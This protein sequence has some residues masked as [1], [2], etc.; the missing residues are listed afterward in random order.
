MT[1]PDLSRRSAVLASLASTLLAACG[2]GGG[3]S[4]TSTVRAINLTSDLA[5]LDFYI[6]GTKQFSSLA[7]GVLAGY[8]SID[9]N[10]YAVSVNSAGNISTLFSGSYTLS[11][12]AHFTAVIWGP[13]AALH[14]SNLPED[15][16]TTTITTGNAKLR[17]LNATVETGPVDIFFTAPGADLTAGPAFISNV[18]SGSLTG[19]FD[20]AAGTG[21]TYELRITSQG[22]P[23]DVRLDIGSV[24]LTAGQYQTLVITA[25]TGATLVNGQIIVQQGATTPLV[26]SQARVRFVSSVDSGGSVAVNVGGT[27]LSPGA[28][29]R[30]AQSAYTSVSAGNVALKITVNGAQLVTT[31]QALTL[32]AGT[33]YTLLV[34]GPP[35]NPQLTTIVDDNRLPLLSGRTKIRLVN[36]VAGLDALSLTVDNVLPVETSYVVAGAASTYAQIASDTAATIIVGS[37]AFPAFYTSPPTRGDQLLG[38][39]VYTMFILSGGASGATPVA[40]LR[41][42]TP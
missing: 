40:V 34:Y 33:D 24:S 26:N 19:F 1:S 32:A 27:A 18:P 25:G 38:Q 2:S 37:A 29:I 42:D 21:S 23:K 35:G 31:P 10:T 12:D 4:G 5:S 3:G 9:A 41:K 30:T 28:L 39:A 36:G 8:T 22:N 16:D 13:Q 20:I 7:S 11:K 17:V 6:G 15:Y 14:V